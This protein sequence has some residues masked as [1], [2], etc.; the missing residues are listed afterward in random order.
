MLATDTQS[1]KFDLTFNIKEYADH[2]VGSAEFDTDLFNESSIKGMTEHFNTLLAGIAD[3]PRQNLSQLPLLSPQERQQILVDWN[4]TRAIYPRNMSMA[5]Q[6]EQQAARRG[7]EIAVDFPDQ[8]LS[9]SQLDQRASQLAHYLSAQGIKRGDRVAICLGRSI[10]MVIG[11]LAILKLNAAYVPLDPHYPE[12]RL[13]FMLEDTQAA[14]IISVSANLQRLQDLPIEKLP[15]VLLLD[16]QEAELALQ[17]DN[18]QTDKDNAQGEQLAYIMYTSGST[19]RPKGVMIPQRAIIR[20]V[21]NTNFVDLGPNDATGHISNVCF[22]AATLE[23]WGALLNG[24]RIIGISK[25]ILLDR[26][27]FEARLREKRV[28]TM[29]ITVTLFNLYVSEAPGMFSSVKNLLVGGE[30]LDPNKI[31]QVLADKPPARLMNGYGPTENTTFT[32]WYEI[33]SLGKEV[34]SVPLGYPLANTTTYILDKNRQPVP[35]G[36]PGE[37]CTGGDGVGLGYLNREDLNAEK[38]VPDP[39][40]DKPGALMYRTGDVCRWLADG[41]IEMLGRVD[42]QVKIRGF[43]IEPGEIDNVLGQIAGVKECAVIVRNDHGDKYLAAYVVASSA[44]GPDQPFASID[45]LVNHIRSNLQEQLPAY[46]QPTAIVVLDELPL[47]SNGKLDHRALPQPTIEQM[48]SAEYIAP[49]NALEQELAQI[50]CE[51]LGIEKVGIKDNFFELGGHSLMATRI[52]AHIKEKLQCELPLQILFEGPTIETLAKHIE[53]AEAQNESVVPALTIFDRSSLLTGIPLSYAQQRLWIIDQ[54]QPG[55][56]MYNIPAAIKISGELNTGVLQRVFATIVARHESLRTNFEG[57]DD[58]SCQVVKPAGDWELPI[59]EMDSDPD[60]LK[61]RAVAFMLAPF[62][63]TAD[64]LFR[65]QLIKLRDSAKPEYVLLACIHHIIS[66]GWSMDVLLHE[67]VTLYQAFSKGEASPLPELGLQYP[68]YALWQRNWLQG[69]VLQN[70]IDYWARQL[71]NAPVLELPT[72]HPRPARMNAHG[73]ITDFSLSADLSAR[74]RKLSKA[75]GSTLYM[76]LLAAFQVLLHRYSGQHDI[77][78]GSPIANRTQHALEPMIGFFVNT[79]VM[80]NQIDSKQRFSDFLQ[81]VRKTT[82]EAYQHQDAPFELVVENLQIPR[83]LSVTPLFQVMLSL[84]NATAF[85]GG[86]ASVNVGELNFSPL[87]SENH[88]EVA[89]KFDLTMNLYDEIEGISGTLEYRAYLFEAETIQQL[90]AHFTQLLESIVEQPNQSIGGLALLSAH[91]RQ[92][93]VIDYNQTQQD[94]PSDNSVIGMIAGHAKT[95]PQ[96]KA[97]CFDEQTFSYA[98][99]ERRANQIANWLQSKGAQQGDF[100]GLYSQRSAMTVCALL[101]IWKAGCVYTPL[102]P[103]HPKD[104]ILYMLDDARLRWVLTQSPLQT[105]L[106][107]ETQTLLIDQPELLD[108]LPDTPV[109]VEPDDSD[110]AYVI[111]TSGTTGQAKGVTIKYHSLLNLAYA[112]QQDIYAGLPVDRPLRVTVNASLVFDASMQQLIQ[113]VFGHTLYP[114]PEDIRL[115]PAAMMAFFRDNAIDVLDCTPSQLTAI[116]EGMDDQQLALLP[117]RILVG[118]E[119]VSVSLW[120]KLRYC[121]EQ[122]GVESFNVYGPTECTVDCTWISV[123]ESASATIGRPIANTQCFILD[124]NLQLAPQGAI[125]ELCVGGAGLSPGYLHREQLT[126]QRFIKNPFGEGRLYRSGDLVRYRPDGC[127]NYVG[128]IDHQVKIRGFR[129][130]LGEIEALLHQHSGIKD[131][132]VSTILDNSVIVAYIVPLGETAPDDKQLRND[133]KQSLP[134]YMIPAAFV[135]LQAIPLT[136]NGKLDRAALPVPELLGSNSEY[137]E[138]QSAVEKQLVPLW[139]DLLQLSQVSRYENFFESGGN[140]LLAIRLLT[141]MREQFDVEI[142]VSMIFEMPVLANMASYIENILWARQDSD[143]DSSESD[144]DREEFEL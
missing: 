81:Q 116:T 100:V 132:V 140:S 130:E 22:D 137:V 12:D 23:F 135:E 72:D 20:L 131:A 48:S 60:L 143:F 8:Q 31:R 79:L 71:A 110:L 39:F 44:Q 86:D 15:E 50:W 127:I 65:A 4:N 35:V 125:G 121:A 138:A 114:V 139:Q 129:I 43:R 142:P 18:W 24:G 78:V 89:T 105:I 85:S 54:I 51:I 5:S 80:R 107:E 103:N 109:Q 61:Q 41:R 98:Q 47:T 63:L 52:T 94:F 82:L 83:T 57:N 59:F 101:G 64:S 108:T 62:D 53:L 115:D 67:I 123:R 90:L 66:D 93:L 111:Y 16:K 29:F 119:A 99:L 56:A 36:V 11:I 26:A 120:E 2:L 118:G 104:R 128:R 30:A 97:V 95:N 124:E 46:M 38:F 113:L 45:E 37:L 73:R 21:K 14:L 7:D 126:A 28:T 40:S 144:E 42:D 69:D 117:K 102:D 84:Q 96:A 34:R 70:Q 32:T 3:N 27:A 55:S 49:R 112:L 134:D 91:E 19:G 58:R 13:A 141:R 10:D 25:E 75:Q 92:R 33:S 122:F 17:P 1:A 133:L 68:D 74:L 9:Y 88:R 106:P 87:L 6:F 76:T 77:S 136:V